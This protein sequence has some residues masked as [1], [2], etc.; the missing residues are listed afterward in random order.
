M[1]SMPL[2][3]E[4]LVAL[5]LVGSGLSAVTGAIGLIV[6]KNFF[7]RMHPLA[8]AYSLATWLVALSSII[9]F[10]VLESQLTVR[11]WT[12]VILL[13]ITMPVTTI[14]LARVALFRSRVAGRSIEGL[15]DGR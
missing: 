12:V 2:W 7:L 8:L 4:A 13:T 15:H 6:L 10:S 14:L 1:T 9:Y 3:I 11:T 5:L